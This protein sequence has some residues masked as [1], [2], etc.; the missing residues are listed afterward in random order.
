MFGFG[1][2]FEGY[3]EIGDRKQTGGGELSLERPF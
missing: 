3:E 2:K 1:E